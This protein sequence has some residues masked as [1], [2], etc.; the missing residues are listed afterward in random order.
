MLISEAIVKLQAMKDKLGD[1]PLY[2]YLSDDDDYYEVS[3]LHEY[4][5]VILDEHG[6]VFS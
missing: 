1:V 6:V 5:D 4:H 2:E 3:E